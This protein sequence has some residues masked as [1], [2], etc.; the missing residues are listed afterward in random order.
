MDASANPVHLWK[1]EVLS[2]GT[3]IIMGVIVDTNS[4]W[5]A[6]RLPSLGIA[7]YWVTAVGDNL[8][9]I[10]EALD[11]AVKRSDIVI[12]TGG[13]GPTD[14]DLTR[15]AIAALLGESPEVA[16]NLEA[17]LRRRFEGR[18]MPERN[19]KQATLIP[20]A[21]AIPNSRG[22]APGWW[23]ET[24]GGAVIISMP[25]VPREMYQMWQDQVVPRLV[26]RMEGRSSVIVTRTLK[27][28]G[29]GEAKVDEMIDVQL[30]SSN[31]KIGVYAKADGTHVRINALGRTEAEAWSVLEPMQK[32][33]LG[34]LGPYVWGFDEDT[35]PTVLQRYFRSSGLTLALMES[36]TGG[37]ISNLLTDAPQAHA[38]LKGAVIVPA[39][40]SLPEHGVPQATMSDYGAASMETARA[41]A[42]AAR[43]RWNADIGVGVAGF[44]P[45]EATGTM[46]V[47][48]AIVADG[49][50]VTRQAGYPANIQDM[51]IRAGN[52]VLFELVDWMRRS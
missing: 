51:K 36:G 15:E 49:G 17:D 38:F 7:N 23:T 16:P 21:Q 12:T 47:S 1:A 13:L 18:P 41:M 44:G 8:D 31:P 28:L 22:T 50:E 46:S 25:G 48:F 6:Q 33:L 2:I 20:S 35:V 30:E 45:T 37:H 9:R 24:P 40:T 4:A 29:I 10:V 5:L 27:V 14:D 32:T 43:Q 26:K 11:R 19:I 52:A 39:H 42:V 34:I 3:E